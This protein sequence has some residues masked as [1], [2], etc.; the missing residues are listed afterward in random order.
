L[1]PNTVEEI[2]QFGNSSTI[3]G[4]SSKVGTPPKDSNKSESFG[5]EDSGVAKESGENSGFTFDESLNSSPPCATSTPTPEREGP[6]NKR[7]SKTSSD[8]EKDT[9]S[10]RAID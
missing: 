8:K 6:K 2:E 4:V 3:P 1:Q 5:S 7:A 10:A 9:F